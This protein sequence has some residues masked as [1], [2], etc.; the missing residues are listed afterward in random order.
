MRWPTKFMRRLGE[1]SSWPSFAV[2][3]DDFN[4]RLRA[5]MAGEDD[6]LSVPSRDTKEP[7]RGLSHRDKNHGL[8]RQQNTALPDGCTARQALQHTETGPFSRG[9]PSRTTSFVQNRL[10]NGR[11]SRRTAAPTRRVF[12]RWPSLGKAP[13]EHH[14]PPSDWARG[15][16]P[17]STRPVHSCM[18]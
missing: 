3:L 5:F 10:H 16:T 6:I 18:C 4:R 2:T 17:V 13:F 12:K 9:P 7:P 1:V 11:V 14:L 8:E 15:R